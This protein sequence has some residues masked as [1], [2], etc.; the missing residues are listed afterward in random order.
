MPIQRFTKGDVTVSYD[1]DKCI[2]AG[3]CV[4]GLP[5]VFDAKKKPWIDPG[6]GTPDEIAAQVAQCPSGALALE[7]AGRP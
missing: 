1:S 3:R 6:G 5:A 7:R 4:K 2:H